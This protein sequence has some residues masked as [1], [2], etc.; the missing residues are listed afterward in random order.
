MLLL[1]DIALGVGCKG[2]FFLDKFTLAV[3]H[4]HQQSNINSNAQDVS[5]DRVT[6]KAIL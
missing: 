1:S 4:Q 2:G 6:S 3:Q 5:V